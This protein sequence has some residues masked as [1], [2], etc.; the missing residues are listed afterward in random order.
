MRSERAEAAQ[1]R[2]LGGL[3]RHMTQDPYPVNFVRHKTSVARRLATG[4]CGGWYGDAVLVLS[5]AVSAL[6]ANLFPGKRIDRKRFTQTWVRYADTA[7]SPR[8][9]S[10]PLLAQD[11][12]EANDN[13]TVECLRKLRPEAIATFPAMVDT[14]VLDGTT[15]DASEADVLAACPHMDSP[16]VREF[17]YASVF[18]SE[19]RSGFVH[20][21]DTTEFGSSHPGGM[22]QAD[23]SYA[24]VIDKPYR[25]IHFSIDWLCR[26]AESIAINATAD[27]HKRP[28]PLPTLWW[29][30]GGAA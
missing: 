28:F 23:I 12:F 22:R 18:Y 14:L 24:N 13:L 16:S 5:S 27:I 2:T 8:L 20:E 11:R 15:S 21:G 19:I 25:R 4:E 7:L 3:I 26:L 17:A 10:V 29:L 1:L 30:E 9:I 6:S